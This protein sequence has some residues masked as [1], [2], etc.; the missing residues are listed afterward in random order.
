LDEYNPQ[1][2][3]IILYILTIMDKNEKDPKSYNFLLLYLS[4]ERN[5]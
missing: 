5:L 2:I 1:K 4:I 3:L